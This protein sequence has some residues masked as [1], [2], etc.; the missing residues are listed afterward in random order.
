MAF[1]EAQEKVIRDSLPDLYKQIDE[2]YTQL[3]RYEEKITDLTQR[4]DSM[5][6]WRKALRLRIRQ[7]GSAT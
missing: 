4:L 6:N 5:E 7:E 3:S 1:T 2:L